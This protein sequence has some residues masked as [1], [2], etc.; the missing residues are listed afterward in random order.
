MTPYQPSKAE[1]EE[2]VSIHASPDEAARALVQTVCVR[3]VKA[4]SVRTG[5]LSRK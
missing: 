5:K 1:L 4:T 3:R 2:E